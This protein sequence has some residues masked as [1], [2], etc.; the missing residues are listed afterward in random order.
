MPKQQK[1]SKGLACLSCRPRKIKCERVD[2]RDERQRR[3]SKEYIVDLENQVQDFKAIL[4]DLQ[5][6]LEAQ[7][8]ILSCNPCREHEIVS[9]QT[10]P[11]P[12]PRGSNN[13]APSNSF[14]TS[15]FVDREPVEPIASTIDLNNRDGL[16]LADTTPSSSSGESIITLLRG[17]RNRLNSSIE[18]GQS[19][20]FGPTSSLHLTENVTSI[21]SYCENISRAGSDFE[22]EI[23]QAMQ[24]YLL[25]L[26]W[27]YQHNVMRII[28]KEAFLAG[29]EAARGPYYSR[30]LLLCILVSGARISANPEIRALSIPSMDEEHTETPAL[31]RLAQDALE[32]EL[33][34]PSITTIQS[35]MLLSVLDC[36]QSD[37]MK[38][39]LK[40]GEFEKHW[41]L[42]LGRPPIIKL[43]DV[44]VR[45]PSKTSTSWDAVIFAA[46]TE[47][48]DIAGQISER[49]NTN[50]CFQEQ[51]NIYMNALET[52]DANMDATLIPSATSPPAVYQLRMQYCALFILLNRHNAGLG[53]CLDSRVSDMLKS[54]RTC[55]EHALQ[56]S[57]LIQDYTAHHQAYTLTGSALYHITLA[58]TTLIAEIAEKQKNNVAAELAALTGCLS[59]MKQM[60]STE[61]VALHVR[62]IVQ[63]I[64]R[65]CDMQKFPMDMGQ[66]TASVIQEITNIPLDE[67]YKPDEAMADTS[68]IG[69]ADAPSAS[70]QHDIFC[71]NSIFQFPFE[72]VLI[73]P[74]LASDFFEQNPG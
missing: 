62:K 26:Y 34:N 29:L 73:D 18:N 72:D 32:K 59:I 3:F 57:R 64:M 11:E 8:A 50:S 37:D 14:E 30:C 2:G 21:L 19:R 4:A 44:Y 71:S 25:E 52:W 63:T 55:V 10:Q 46:W 41:G 28:H 22:K 47:I 40:S 56:I 61:I 6:Q 31:F 45:K 27:N 69:G 74:Y 48:L 38:G 51:I 70:I 15:E 54:R 24:Q 49:L 65:V 1:A 9:S 20:Y 68:V 5:S 39:W 23:P 12:Q 16:G 53:T 13:I 33:L 43:C 58:A 67:T 60:E 66:R 36:I 17:T 42:Y 7:Q 35:L